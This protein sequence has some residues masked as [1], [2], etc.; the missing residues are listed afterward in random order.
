MG[1]LV[2]AVSGGLR[3]ATE[4]AV[5]GSHP[6]A[7]TDD[8]TQPASEAASLALA[9][10]RT[11]EGEPALA[12]E[13]LGQADRQPPTYD[14]NLLAAL[15]TLLR[16]RLLSG[17]GDASIALAELRIARQ[18][19]PSRQPEPGGPHRAGS[20]TGGWIARTLRAAQADALTCLGR[21][22]DA[23]ALLHEADDGRQQRDLETEISLQRALLAARDPERDLTRLAEAPSRP[24]HDTTSPALEI[25]RWLLLAEGSIADH[26]SGAALGHLDQ[27][28][29]LA[30]PNHLRRPILQAAESVQQL[31]ADSGLANRNRWLQPR[32]VAAGSGQLVGSISART[33]GPESDAYQPVVIALTKKET[34]VLGH[35]AE[36]LTTDEIAAAMFV[37]VNTVR[38]HVRSILRKLGV[39]RRNEA[40]RRAWDFQI[41]PP[42][43]AA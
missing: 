28:L 11:D 8:G 22:R 29:R 12:H 26:D 7:A 39:S 17:Q 37:S 6:G 23:I 27:A 3:R 15:A 34:E 2:E 30:A 38:S 13:L 42:R 9:W 1:A 24:L 20:S 16:A 18:P 25:D 4:M 36:L 43:G 21:P 31:L 40:V 19:E 14:S 35:L 33:T 32:S 5:E 10:V 41:L